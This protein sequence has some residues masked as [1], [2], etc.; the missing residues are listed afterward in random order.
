MRQGSSLLL[1]AALALIVA[2]GA[3]A[4]PSTEKLSG[5]E[6]VDVA[7]AKGAEKPAE[8]PG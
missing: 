1:A 3:L 7:K 4:K 5:A 2:A 6:R 8:T